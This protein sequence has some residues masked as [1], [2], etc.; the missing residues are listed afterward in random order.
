MSSVKA[1]ALGDIDLEMA[2]TRRVLERVPDE[3]M[4]WRP[5]ERSWTLGSLAAHIANLPT[6]ITTIVEQGQFDLASAVP[7]NMPPRTTAELL[8]MFDRNVRQLQAALKAADNLKLTR[9]W[10]LRRG[11]EIIQKQE[12]W[13][14]MRVTGLNHLIHH[15]AQLTVYLRLL[16]VPVPGL[17]GP[18]ADEK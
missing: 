17:Y 15:R 11:D 12:R 18:S 2:N 13:E 3:Q 7:P 14:A 1:L 8:E 5:H 9:D 10:K 4:N 6:W 16:D